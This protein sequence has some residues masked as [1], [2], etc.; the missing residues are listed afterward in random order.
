MNEA[1]KKLDESMKQLTLDLMKYEEGDRE[2]HQ[3]LNSLNKQYQACKVLLALA[4]DGMN[5]PY[6]FKCADIGDIET[7]LTNAGY[8][9]K[10]QKSSTR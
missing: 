4:D 6:Y 7:L 2:Y 3:T 10:Q 9:E 8:I 5:N 1:L